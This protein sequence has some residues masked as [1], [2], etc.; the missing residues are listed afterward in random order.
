[1]NQ[2]K[3]KAFISYSHHGDALFAQRLQS[4]LEKFAKPWNSARAFRVFRDKTNLSI[5]PGLWPEIETALAESEHLLLL[6]SP[7][8]AA[9]K[10]IERELQFWVATKEI[11]HLYITKTAGEIEWDDNACD[12]DWTKTNCIPP[13]LKKM[14]SATPFYLDCTQFNFTQSEDADKLSLDDKEFLDSVA[15]IAAKLH[16]KEKDEIFGEH[17]RQHRKTMRLAWS[18]GITLACLSV[19]LTVALFRENTQRKR[20]EHQ[21]RIANSQRLAVEAQTLLASDRDPQT[22]LLLAAEALKITEAASEVRTPAA[23]ESIRAA[24]A[25]VGGIGLGP[26]AF[27]NSFFKSSQDGRWLA[28]S[29]DN[30]TLKLWDL[31]QA[32][33]V[34]MRVISQDHDFG[35]LRFSDDSKWLISLEDRE[36]RLWSVYSAAQNPQVLNNDTTVSGV[37]TTSDGEW[38]FATHNTG[39]VTVWRFKD[40]LVQESPVTIQLHQGEITAAT[41]S[42]DGHFF[43]TGGADKTA[44][45]W[46]LRKADPWSSPIL[47]SGHTAAVSLIEV[48]N[49]G[50]RVITGGGDNVPRYWRIKTGPPVAILLNKIEKEIT[51][52]QLSPDGR[53]M[54]SGGEWADASLCDLNAPDP[55]AS[56]TILSSYGGPVGIAVFSPDSKLIVTAAG[57]APDE[58]QE[59]TI[60]EPIARVW[61]LSSGVPRPTHQLKGHTDVILN[62]VFLI[63]GQFLA[64]SSFDGTIRVWRVQGENPETPVSVLRADN[65]PAFRM[66]ETLEGFATASTDGNARL[67]RL[68]NESLTAAPIQMNTGSSS[69]LSM[70][71]DGQWLFQGGRYFIL[72]NLRPSDP[73]SS[74][75]VLEWPSDLPRPAKATLSH[76]GGFLAVGFGEEKSKRLIVLDLRGGLHKSKMVPTSI[77]LRDIVG[78]SVTDRWLIIEIQ[79]GSGTEDLEFWDLSAPTPTNRVSEF[80]IPASGLKTTAISKN[81]RLLA[82]SHADGRIR[83]VSLVSPSGNPAASISKDNGDVD[84]LLL[85]PESNWLIGYGK[86]DTNV[87]LWRVSDGSL[88]SSAFVLGGHKK[89]IQMI[90]VSPDEHWLA[91]GAFGEPLLLW[92]LQSDNFSRP[93]VALPS[94]ASISMT[95]KFSADGRWL[96]TTSYEGGVHLWD[97]SLGEKLLSRPMNLQGHRGSL[98][99]LAFSP[100]S[101]W[102]V[103][104]DT[105]L[106]PEKNPAKTCRIWDLKS[107]TLSDSSVLL[108]KN[109]LPFGADRV[110]ISLD[111][112]WL[113]TSSV[114]GVRLWPLGIQE[115]IHLAERTTGRSFTEDEKRMYGVAII[116]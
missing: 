52:L 115:L 99:R 19:L 7:A 43:V 82:M 46:D 12:F 64:T 36:I 90:S 76:D 48:S 54:V 26:V 69:I 66:V 75:E 4:A 98:L 101:H 45:I 40:A 116:Q 105:T 59:A 53:W 6:A 112:R 60:P 44:R 56:Y 25:R 51:W 10:W 28:A 3:Y 34:S 73:S 84:E 103:T 108:P 72:W 109:G 89:E 68:T 62:M 61:D 86:S 18:A 110:D 27:K 5:A 93:F 107:P 91:T 50:Q 113:I 74:S 15:T 37:L 39:T 14:F 111:G 8:A 35:Y 2:M 114:D 102:L 87:K 57:L 1:M 80:G 85:S 67:W 78:F 30:R 17:I 38:L 9:S 16:G 33:A 49:D 23:E 70:S 55:A 22:A 96:A 42:R 94:N 92:D 95:A 65:G 13:A 104:A 47:L 21:S 83:L 58:L 79:N 106:E 41:V 81:G 77:A 63:H 31:R 24:L 97:L 32:N 71:G 11:S 20:A 29:V 100:D 88:A